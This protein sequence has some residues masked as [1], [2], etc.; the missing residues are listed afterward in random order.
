MRAVFADDPTTQVLA[1]LFD[2]ADRNGDGTL[3]RT[4]FDAFFDL[5]EAGVSCR[6]VVTVTDRG[7]NLYDLFD[8]DGDG[9]LTPAELTRAGRE[10]PGELARDGAVS[11][12]A[13]PAGY[14]LTVAPGTTWGTFGPVPLGAAAA[15]RPMARPAPAAVPRWFAAMDRNRDGFVSAAE[16]AGPP[17]VFA[18]FDRDADGRISPAEA[19]A[20]ER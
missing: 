8:R 12:A 20:A 6:V 9:R 3:T 17:A 2:P 7:R 11:P 14:R 13:V 19:A 5:I 1:A 16:F 10:R 4:E 15:P 18:E